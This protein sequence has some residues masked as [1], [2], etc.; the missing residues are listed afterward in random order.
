M[1]TVPHFLPAHVGVCV[2]AGSPEW[3]GLVSSGEFSHLCLIC[4]AVCPGPCVQNGHGLGMQQVLSPAV[5]LSA[6]IDWATLLDSG[7]T[8]KIRDW[9]SISIKRQTV[10]I[11]TVMGHTLSH[12]SRKVIVHERMSGSIPVKRSRKRGGGPGLAT[13]GPRFPH[14]RTWPHGTPCRSPRMVAL[15]PPQ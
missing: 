6:S 2:S 3:L 14:C 10:R 4:Q 7:N 5:Y 1:S 11:F 12:Y 13:L 9:Q 8:G 15:L